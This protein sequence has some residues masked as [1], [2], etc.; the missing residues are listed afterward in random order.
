VASARPET[1]HGALLAQRILDWE[2]FSCPIDGDS[3]IGCA[4]YLAFEY[5]L[6]RGLFDDELGELARE[7]VGGGAS[8]QALIA[9][10]DEPSSPWWDDGT[11][12]V[13]QETRD[14]I[15]SDALDDA[16]RELAAAYGNDPAKWTWGA[17][18]TARF[19]EATLGISGI[20]PLEWYFDKGPFAAP[21]AA[22]AINNT[23]YRPSRAYPDPDDPDY[24]P[25]GIN[26]LFAVTNL[27]SYRLSIDM[28]DLDGARIVQTTGQSGNPFDRHYGD[29]ID[30]WLTGE[31]VP[32]A[33][34]PAAVREATIETLVLS[35]RGGG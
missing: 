11:T 8:W 25:V 34:T 23:Y 10:I 35:P 31:T 16:G 4:A 20:G 32:L 21:G 24:E 12:R 29:L 27:P 7:Y 2:T 18:H 1:E 26:G 5:R 30:D 13:L 14:D 17:L 15:V 33:F 28:K 6:V 3:S 9:L 22:G 19:E